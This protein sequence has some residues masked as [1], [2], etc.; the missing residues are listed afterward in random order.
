MA[1]PASRPLVPRAYQC[2]TNVLAG[3]Y[4][5]SVVLFRRQSSSASHF[6]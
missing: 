2:R 5:N 6:T 1:V 3:G 4:E